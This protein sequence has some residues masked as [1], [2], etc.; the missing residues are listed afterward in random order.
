MKLKS[1]C[2]KLIFDVAY[3]SRVEL[4]QF[5]KAA[6]ILARR[7]DV[8]SLEV[9]SELAFLSGDEGYGLSLIVDAITRTL[10]KSDWAKARSL[11]GNLRQIQ[12][13]V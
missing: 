4:K 5:N 2:Y 10:V 11:T 1:S 6:E 9:A 8:H 13:N 3:I 7:K 12:V